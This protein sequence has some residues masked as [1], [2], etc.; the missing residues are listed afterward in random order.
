LREDLLS[1]IQEIESVSLKRRWPSTIVVELTKKRAVAFE[2]EKDGYFLLDEHGLR[3][4]EVAERP[5][6]LPELRNTLEKSRRASAL[7]WLSQSQAPIRALEWDLELGL[8]VE[9]LDGTLVELGFESF[10][11]SWQKAERALQY[12]HGKQMKAR[13]LDATYNNRV[14]ARGLAK[15]QNPENDLN[16]KEMVHREGDRP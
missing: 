14:V 15:L 13:A 8:R 3:F 12:I 6:A 9:S 5:E 2:I 7:S 11:T 16:L 1:N 4:K 10:S